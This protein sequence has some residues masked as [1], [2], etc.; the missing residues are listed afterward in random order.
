MIHNCLFNLS[1]N[2]ICW[3]SKRKEEVLLVFPWE[4]LSIKRLPWLM[5]IWS[6][7]VLLVFQHH[8]RSITW[9]CGLIALYELFRME[10]SGQGFV[11]LPTTNLHARKQY[12][13]YFS[14]FWRQNV[15]SF[16]F[17]FG[18]KH[19]K[20]LDVKDTYSHFRRLCNIFPEGKSLNKFYKL[21]EIL[22][23]FA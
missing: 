6:R 1:F 17:A 7:Y 21:V 2:P 18:K 16:V 9:F 14:T 8:L 19:V 12:F 23:M 11:L 5:L 3:C 20:C 22:L 4:V 10:W 13:N 15:H